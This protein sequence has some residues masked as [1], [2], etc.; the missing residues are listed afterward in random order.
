MTLICLFLRH[1]CMKPIHDIFPLIKQPARVVIT[2]HQKPDGDAMGS[3][4]GL[5]GFLKRLGHEVA[6]I[7]PPTGRAG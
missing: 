6:V 7:S 1:F 3:A 5:C 2:M 4:L